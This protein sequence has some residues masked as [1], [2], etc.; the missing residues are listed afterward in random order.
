VVLESL[1][2]PKRL[3]KRPAGSMVNRRRALVDTRPT[4][5]VGN[6]QATVHERDTLQIR[7]THRP[8]GGWFMVICRSTPSGSM[9]NSPRSECPSCG[10]ST[11]YL[12]HV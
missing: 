6:S 10:R 12:P 11:P 5:T 7:K 3:V 2:K 9:M 8:T 4:W 1:H